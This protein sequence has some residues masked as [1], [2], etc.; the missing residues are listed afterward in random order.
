[1][2]ALSQQLHVARRE[3]EGLGRRL[4]AARRELETARDD[5]ASLKAD[6]AA[7]GPRAGAAPG[8]REEE[9]RQL[10]GENEI[11][12]RQVVEL[13]IAVAEVEGEKLELKQ[14]LA[15]AGRARH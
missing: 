2:E 15:R 13:K 5:V 7:G 12:S 9:L 14:Q 6:A 10:V 11:L 4:E 3:A 1:V 8:D